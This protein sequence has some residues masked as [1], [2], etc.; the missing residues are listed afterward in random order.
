MNKITTIALA[1]V[2]A[3]SFAG[4]AGAETLVSVLPASGTQTLGQ[5]FSASVELS[6]AP[7]SVCVVSGDIVFNNLSCQSIS[8]AS[9]VMAQ[10]APTCQNTHF[11]VG[12]AQCASAVKTLLNISASASNVGGASI[13]LA[14][15][16]TL[17]QHGAV[18]STAVNGSYTV[19]GSLIASESPAGLIITSPTVGGASTVAPDST[20]TPADN[21]TTTEPV[22]TPQQNTSAVSGSEAS[23]FTK[24]TAWILAIILLLIISYFIVK[25]FYAKN[26]TQQP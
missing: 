8:L 16:Q 17:N 3:M 25:R 15:V 11:V 13:S 20:E 7:N 1:S 23:R 10:T 24:E 22:I 9:G 14:N 4:I 18:V 26:P 2:I 21:Q 6:P 12:V 5:A 19:Q